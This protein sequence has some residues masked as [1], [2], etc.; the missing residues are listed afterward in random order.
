ME[1]L[2]DKS[3][4][5]KTTL[6]HRQTK[7]TNSKPDLATCLLTC[8]S[9]ATSPRPAMRPARVPAPKRRQSTAVPVLSINQPQPE[10]R[11]TGRP[12]H[13][14]PR[15]TRPMMESGCAKTTEESLALGQ[16]LLSEG[17]VVTDWQTRA[18]D[19]ASPKQ[20][21]NRHITVELPRRTLPGQDEQ[22]TYVRYK[23]T[24]EDMPANR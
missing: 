7:D 5:L 6:R 23:R 20:M 8:S 15:R 21:K 11:S 10:T 16:E 19:K 18:S 9:C 24:A 22:A 13:A 2:K 17:I 14:R 4:H 12:A 3:G 1:S